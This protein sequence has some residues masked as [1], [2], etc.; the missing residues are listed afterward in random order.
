MKAF[1]KSHLLPFAV[2]FL[3]SIFSLWPIIQD[4]EKRVAEKWDGVLMV[5]YL[6]QTIK[7][8]PFDLSNLFQANIFYS[9]KNVMAFSD[10]HI[11]SAIISYIPVLLTKEP[12]VAISTS[13][14]F[15]QITTIIICYLWFWEASKSKT[16]ALISSLA[17]G[18]SVTRMGFIAHL[19]M[20]N[21]QWW[22]FSVYLIWKYFRKK[23]FW[24]LITSAIFFGAQMWESPL[25]VYFAGL[26]ILFLIIDNF[27]AFWEKRVYFLIFFL[28]SVS[29]VFI[30]A[31][32]YWLVAKEYHLARSI[33]DAAN[34][35]PGIDE[36]LKSVFSDGVFL[37]MLLLVF[38]KKIKL[39]HKGERWL[40]L[41]FLSGLILSLGPVLKIGDFTLKLFNKFFLPLPYGILYYLLPGFSAFRAPGRW[42]WLALFSSAFLLS[43]GLAKVIKGKK[44]DKIYL[45][46]I[47]L[48]IV[49]FPLTQR[50]NYFV[51]GK[52]SEYPKVY[53]YIKGLPQGVL[54]ELPIFSWAFGE[55]AVLETHR[56]VYSLYHG[57]YLLGGVSGFE[58][59]SINE[60]RSL[61]WQNFPSKEFDDRI[62]NTGVD[63]LLIWK[64]LIDE[65][66]L[67]KVEKYYD[68]FLYNDSNHI[69]IK[70]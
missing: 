53:T 34:F 62:K 35:S 59:E 20:W 6:N 38:F 24:Y 2:I 68:T 70:I 42:I 39:S 27:K 60:L 66:R 44:L 14:L 19:Q 28:V 33:R 13:L 36:L 54:L 11:P 63:Y 56:M 17:L 57:K 10:M 16:A 4:P 55:V 21:H 9:Y 18:I 69:L 22:L 7:K 40:L 49:F 32:I 3:I 48:A 43:L 61:Y 46:F 31:R 29:I 52:V 47:I 25:G 8:I 12:L 15:G 45:F 5:W 23:V 26:I 1:L 64:G 51:F 37:A 30:P 65:E 50:A 67:D 41:L 58:P